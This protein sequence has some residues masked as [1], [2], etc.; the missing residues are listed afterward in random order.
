MDYISTTDLRTKSSSLVSILQKGG[1][2]SLIHRSKVIA[3]IKPKKM[4]TYLK[5]K[6]IQDLKNLAKELNLPES[7]YEE[8]EMKYKKNLEEKYGK[9]I[10]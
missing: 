7:S 10:S 4:I 9:N 8:R 3:E 2:I 1:S 6:D 5:S